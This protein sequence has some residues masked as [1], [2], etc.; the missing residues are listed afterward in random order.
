[1]I[2]EGILSE[3]KINSFLAMGYSSP[4]PPVACVITDLNGE[5]L[6][7]AH[8]QKTG[9]NHAEREAYLKLGE[10]FNKEHNVYVTL[11]PCSHFG[12]TPPCL[13][14]ILK[15]KPKNVFIGIEDPNPLVRQISSVTKLREQNINVE[16]STEI[17]K[18]ATEFLSGFLSRMKKKRPRYF[19]KAALSKEGFYKSSS[20]RRENLSSDLSNNI[21][22]IVRQSMDAIIVGP[23]T[24][25]YDSPKLNFRGIGDNFIV[26]LNSK[27]LYFDTINHINSNKS[28]INNINKRSNQPFRI[29]LI[30]EKY[31]P[32]KLFFLN[33]S[34]LE[35]NKNIFICLDDLSKG[36]IDM[37]REITS[38]EIYF[39]NKDNFNDVLK[40]IYNQFSLNTIL[41][42]GGNYI[43]QLFLKDLESSDKIIEI[44]TNTPLYEGIS[45]VWKNSIDI[46]EK[47]NFYLNKE[48]WVLK[49]I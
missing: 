3:L 1:M 15:Y 4:N 11:E 41:A 17:Y 38:N 2:S 8:T 42:E 28:L 49:G 22:Q 16:F 48:N 37:L 20:H 35:S 45:P 9:F 40:D 25:F 10:S 7:S 24:V 12:K 47:D 13:D 46:I 34:K 31:F 21:S 6:S 30:S 33:Q 19:L 43:Y 23:K 14:L 5:I 26:N 39:C 29:F 32:E 18:I 27:D 44:K 36:N